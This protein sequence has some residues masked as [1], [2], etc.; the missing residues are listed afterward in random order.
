MGAPVSSSSFRPPLGIWAVIA[1]LMFV[2]Y[3]NFVTAWVLRGILLDNPDG[4]M[5]FDYA[6]SHS[7]RVMAWISIVNTTLAA[8]AL[9]ILVLR[10]YR[11][12]IFWA[13]ASLITIFVLGQL[14]GNWARSFYHLSDDS[15]IFRVP[16]IS[17]ALCTVS[18]GYLLL[19]PA[20]NAFYQMNTGEIITARANTLWRLFRARDLK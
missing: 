19:S 5:P 11:S 12:S 4:P 13:V 3:R 7:L 6:L 20:V 9:I 14:V 16:L 8:S 1:L 2:T 18:C 17:I 15:S 10:Q